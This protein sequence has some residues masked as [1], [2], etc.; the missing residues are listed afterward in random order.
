MYQLCGD[1][2]AEYTIASTSQMMD[3]NTGA[4]SKVIFDKFGL[5]RDILPKLIAPG[6]KVSVLNKELSD[7]LGCRRIPVIAVG[8]HDTASAVAGVPVSHDKNWAYLSSGTWSLMGIEIDGPIINQTSLELGFTNEGGVEGTIRFLK[9]I[10]GLWLI[11]ECRRQ[12]ACDGQDMDYSQLTKMASEAKPFQAY[13]NSDCEDF[14][15]PGNMPEKINRHLQSTGQA[16]LDDKGE[17]IRVI[18]E[19]LAGQYR[20][21]LEHLEKFSGSSIE[22]L[23]IVGGGTKNELLNQLTAN[24]TGKRIVTGPVEATVLGNVLS[25]AKACGQIQSLARGRKIIAESFSLKQYQPVEKWED[26]VAK[27]PQPD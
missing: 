25:Q 16:T 11:Q 2:S 9:N 8:S 1:I 23:H 20:Q 3:M 10:M 14:I 7:E 22:V 12:W 4:W 24:A 26:V 6:T 17:L 13:I 18:L 5:P 15:S 21:T 27:F 19:S